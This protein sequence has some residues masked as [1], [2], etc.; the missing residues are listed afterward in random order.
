MIA[1]D[2]FDISPD[3]PF[4]KYFS[5]NENPVSWIK[6]IGQVLEYEMFDSQDLAINFPPNCY[7]GSNV[8]IH[9]TVKLPPVCVINGP[10]YIGANTTIRP[11]AYIRENVIVGENCVI[12]NSCEIKN[13][14]LL[15]NV[16]VPHFNYVGDSV[17]GNFAHLGAGAICANLKLDKTPINIHFNG[18]RIVTGLV[19]MGAI[20]GDHSDVACNVVLNPG[21]VLA[22]NSKILKNV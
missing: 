13:S 22:K 4:L 11:F 2:F 14:I 5:P 10:A 15:N 1:K 3:W 19:K 18:E 12:G 17:L 21:S 16:Q 7:I 20:I 8:Y 6:K 9:K